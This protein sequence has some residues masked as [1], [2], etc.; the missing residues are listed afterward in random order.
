ME[1]P[2]EILESLS[3]AEK[4]IRAAQEHIDRSRALYP[5]DQKFQLQMDLAQSALD[6]RKKRV[7]E[8][9]TMI[10]VITE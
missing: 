6:L 8:T 4:A 9:K 5:R 10:S 1:L 2:P 7:R 3:E